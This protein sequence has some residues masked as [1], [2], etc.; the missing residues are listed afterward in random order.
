MLVKEILIKQL[1]DFGVKHIYNY[2][3]DTTLTFISALKNSNIKLFSTKHEGAAGMMASAESKLTDNLAVCLSHSGPGTANILNGIADAA[4]DRVPML[5]IS[6]Q[7]E[8]YNIGTNFKQFINLMELTNPF[9]VYSSILINPETIVDLLFKAVSMAIAKGGIS[10]IIIPMD[11]WDMESSAFCRKYPEHLKIKK[12]P[13]INL[14]K[15]AANIINQAEKPIIIYGRGC[16]NIANELIELAEKISSPILSTL[17]AAG[18]IDYGFPFEMGVLGHSGNQYASQLLKEADLIIKLAATWWPVDYTPREPN[19]IQFDA[20]REN[21]G[22]SHPVTLGIPGDI[23]LSIT[24]LQNHLNTKKNNSWI[25]QTKGIKNK[26]IDEVNTGYSQEKW[27]LAPSQV[28][29]VFSEN[30]NENDI[31]SLDSGDNVIFFGKF[32]GNKCKDI[33]ISGT[34]RTMGF[35]LSAALAAKINYPENNS[36]VITGD[37]GLTM[38]MSELLTANRYNLPITIIVL[39][40]GNLAMEKNRMIEAGLPTEEVELT[41]PD[42]VKLAESCGIRGIRVDSLENLKNT[43][44]DARNSNVA[45]LIDVPV[46][47]PIIPGTKLS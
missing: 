19:I 31:I 43:I 34:W 11:V 33:L 7:V 36:I 12:I 1:E 42:F 27:P 32:F 29:K 37:G 20:V 39:N 15:Q 9:T 30:C 45:V 21:I 2:P 8:T 6:G 25:E 41:N 17:P 16:K 18:I 40:N 46:S 28:I 47:S 26:W 38:V 44:N 35:G 5:L 4:S 3:G 10:H 14:I 24:E 13:D 23:S 22:S